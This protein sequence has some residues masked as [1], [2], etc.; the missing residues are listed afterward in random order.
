[1]KNDVHFKANI[2]FKAIPCITAYI[3]I[4]YYSYFWIMTA[5]NTL[6]HAAWKRKN[7]LVWLSSMI[8]LLSYLSKWS[9]T[10]CW[11]HLNKVFINHS[12]GIS[13]AGKIISNYLGIHSLHIKAVN[14]VNRIKIMNANQRLPWI[15]TPRILS[16]LIFSCFF[17]DLIL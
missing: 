17:G 16:H 9:G 3:Q 14:T 13:S 4:L 7:E 12:L 11:L 6:F 15:C 5:T 10:P 1:M 2:D 8:R